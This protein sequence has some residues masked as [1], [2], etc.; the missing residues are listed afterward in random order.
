MFGDA[1]FRFLAEVVPAKRLAA[2]IAEAREDRCDRETAHPVLDT[3]FG[4]QVHRLLVFGE[5]IALG[6]ALPDRPAQMPAVDDGEVVSIYDMFLTMPRSERIGALREMPSATK[7]ALWHHHLTNMEAEHPELSPE[8][9]RIIED[10]RTL[11]TPDAYD[12]SQSDPR[13]K[14]V[15]ES[16]L[17]DIRRRAVAAFPHD[18]LIAVF[19]DMRPRDSSRPRATTSASLHPSP[20]NISACTCSRDHDDCFYWEGPGSY[21]SLGCL[22]TKSWGC[23]PGF[24]FRCDG[25]CTPPD[26]T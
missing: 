12:L 10:F 4:D 17:E 5:E 19:L 3:R 13:F 22:W 1:F 26:P 20:A 24:L 11:L 8:Q 9:R 6:L 23:G 7:V 18:L 21:C 15:V 25:Y 14:S 16:P 2:L